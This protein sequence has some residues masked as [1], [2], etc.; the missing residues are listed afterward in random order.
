MI[1]TCKARLDWLVE[2]LGA[3]T[4][5][6]EITTTWSPGWCRRAGSTCAR[7]AAPDGKQLYRP[8]TARTVNKTTVSLL[9]RVLRRARDNWNAASSASRPG[10]T[11]C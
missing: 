3:N 8:I 2:Q 10:K 7:P 6:H 1:P 5:L 4:P 11:I 9:R